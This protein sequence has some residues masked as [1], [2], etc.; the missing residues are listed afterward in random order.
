MK[1]FEELM[2]EK[3][4]DLYSAENQILKA[5]PKMQQTALSP[6]LQKIFE[7]DLEEVKKQIKRLED[8]GA[9]LNLEVNGKECKGMKGLITEAMELVKDED[10]SIFRDAALI[11]N[12]QSIEHYEIAGYGAAM[13]YAKLL[14]AREAINL[15]KETIEEEKDSDMALT[16]LAEGL[17]NPE[18][19]AEEEL[20]ENSFQGM[21]L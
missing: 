3:L 14:G 11:A 2:E 17:I 6:E 15:L 7:N 12:T 5:L 21:S 18:A 1:N 20:S 16:A 8:V 19:K 9:L 4:Q 13:A 10:K